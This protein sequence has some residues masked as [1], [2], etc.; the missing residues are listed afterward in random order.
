MIP[1]VYVVH[2]KE[3]PERTRACEE[4]LRSVGVDPIMWRSIHGRT[5]GLET[6]RE[7][8]LGRRISPGHVGLLLGHWTLWN[9][10]L[11]DQPHRSDQTWI[12]F[13]DDVLLPE[14]KPYP[15]KGFADRFTSQLN[16]VLDELD[17]YNPD[18]DFVFLGLAEP[19]GPRV[20]NK[21]T[22]RIGPPGSRLC[23][24][25]WPWG[26]H[27]YMVRRRALPILLDNMAMAERN[28]DQQLYKNVLSKNLLNWCAV[29]PSLVR[30]RTYDH[31]GVGKPE[32]AP[33]TISDADGAHEKLVTE[34]G[35]V[36]CEV[37]DWPLKES[38]EDGCV[39]G[40]CAYRPDKGSPEYHRIQKRRRELVEAVRDEDIVQGTPLKQDPETVAASLKLTDPYP[41][42]YRGESLEIVGSV[43]SKSIPLDLCARQ[44]RPCYSRDVGPTV[45]YKD[46][47]GRQHLAAQCKTCDLRQE[48][49]PAER[50]RER[51]PL[52]EG[53]F[54]PSLAI[55][56]GRTILATRDSWGHSKVAL[57]DLKSPRANWGARVAA[58]TGDVTQISY[59][60]PEW[61]CDP[62]A[63]IASE[64]PE[65]P[66]LE[67]PR[68]FTMPW[69]TPDSERRLC[70]VFNLPDGYPPKLVQVGY[71]VF[72]EDLTRFDHF[73]V[74]KSPPGNLYEKNWTPFWNPNEQTLKWSYAWKP[75][76]M[77]IEPDHYEGA[78]GEIPDVT[79]HATPNPLPWTGGVIRG[80]AAP[81]RVDFGGG[82][83]VLYYFFHGAL[84]RPMGTVYTVGCLVTE[85]KPPYRVLRQTPTPL[86]WPDLPSLEETVVKRY[87]VWPGGAILA[88]GSWWIALGIDDTYCRIARL[89]IQEVDTALKDVPEQES[90][91]TTSIRDTAIAHG[92]KPD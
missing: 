53:H 90:E 35:V 91:R 50:I 19:D 51:L 42:I 63:S 30:Q 84:K 16:A 59:G 20:W 74:F 12:M 62:I 57:W 22:E 71:G 32:W 52:P 21:I 76:H 14:A 70:S 17:E 36:R 86:I 28:I 81:V 83:E 34:F 1:P 26:T 89:S 31:D 85:G 11:H 61:S 55:Y 37:C 5:W 23:R 68:L 43:G 75:F 58:D 7:Y 25:E 10:L 46:D 39:A 65:A 67:D 92:V 40:N 82:E 69:P 13:E 41:C 44:N 3:L 54:N 15:E 27:A 8:D 47:L 38:I 56:R 72:S 9:H 29:L 60:D 33:S 78:T 6:V 80:G 64:H 45:T 66:R 4:H 49:V 87:V 24:L 79:T 88:Y 48:M 73:E 2:C 77:V 18:W